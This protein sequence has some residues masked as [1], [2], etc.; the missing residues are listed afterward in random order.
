VAAFSRDDAGA[1]MTALVTERRFGRRHLRG[2]G[3]DVGYY[4]SSGNWI[5]TGSYGTSSSGTPAGTSTSSSSS[6]GGGI[7]WTQILTPLAQ[8][9]AQIGKQ[10]ASY[11]NPIYSLAP[12]TYYQQGPYGTVVSTAGVP[13]TATTAAF[14]SSLTSVM[15]L[16]LLAGGVVLVISLAKR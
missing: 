16:L 13:S 11:A 1:A 5:Q 14:T 9:G 2:L 7:N 6:S 3:Q 15:P 10:F 4:D 8:A 12:G